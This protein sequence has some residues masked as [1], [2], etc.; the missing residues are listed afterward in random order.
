MAAWTG[1]S[2]TSVRALIHRHVFRNPDWSA[3]ELF[4]RLGVFEVG[5][6]RFGRFLEGR[7]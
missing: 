6:T 1:S 2:T 3:E 4:E 5:D 7:A